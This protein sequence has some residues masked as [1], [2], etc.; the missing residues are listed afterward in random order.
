MDW[1][2]GEVA[3]GARRTNRLWAERNTLLDDDEGLGNGIS[4]HGTVAFVVNTVQYLTADRYRLQCRY[5]GWMTQQQG[6]TRLQHYN[7]SGGGNRGE[8]SS[9][10]YVICAMSWTLSVSKGKCAHFVDRLALQF[11]S[12]YRPLAQTH[13]SPCPR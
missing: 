13:P 4:S 11:P 2:V 8:R 5:L 3:L 10:R 12:R 9:S 6:E 1:S 7:E